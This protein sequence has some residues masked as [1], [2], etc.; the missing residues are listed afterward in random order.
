M[1]IEPVFAL[2]FKTF[3]WPIHRIILTI[4]VT[5]IIAEHVAIDMQCK[6][7]YA[8]LGKLWRR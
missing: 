4:I 5:I 7:Y 2:K 1:Q 3:C 8:A 6:Y